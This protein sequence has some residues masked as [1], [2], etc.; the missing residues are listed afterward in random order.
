[1]DK[2]LQDIINSS[3]EG[4]C[5]G[6]SMLFKG[7]PFTCQ[8]DYRQ[9]LKPVDVL[10]I[11]DSYTPDIYYPGVYEDSEES[12][13]IIDKFCKDLGVKYTLLPA[14]KCPTKELE[15][16]DIKIC[17]HYV[18]QDVMSLNPKPKLIITMG[19]LALKM[20]MN[21]SNLGNKRGAFVGNFCGVP[22]V[23]TF[24][25]QEKRFDPTIVVNDIFIAINIYIKGNKSTMSLDYKAVRDAEDLKSEL[26]RITRDV[27]EMSVDIET[28]GLDFIHHK[29][30]TVSF[31]TNIGTVVTPVYHREATEDPDKVLAV[32][33][34]HLE[35]PQIRKVFHNADFDW[36]FFKRVGI[37]T[38]N[39]G[40]SMLM[41]FLINENY[42]RKLVSLVRRYFAEEID[43]I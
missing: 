11:A 10:F 15:K 14:S 34:P 42:P 25:L 28:E 5:A 16:E 13:V 12:Q 23:P 29:I 32:M 2:L 8:L 17:R 31:T 21:Q 7:L 20:V 24:C 35:N 6:C 18:T 36:K 41:A 19:E 30:T 33:K 1:M 9:D 27:T 40:D 43:E 4:G 22:V 37:H 3:Q 38:D 26:E 39:V